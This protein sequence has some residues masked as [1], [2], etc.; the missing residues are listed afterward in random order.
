MPHRQ[1]APSPRSSRGE[2]WDEGQT[3]KW[4]AFRFEGD[5]SEINIDHPEGGQKPEFDAWRWEKIERLPELIIPFKR[6][7]YLSVVDHFKPLAEVA[8]GSTSAHG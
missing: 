7:V 1:Y 2:G 4:F 5:E 6:E 3:Q 8:A